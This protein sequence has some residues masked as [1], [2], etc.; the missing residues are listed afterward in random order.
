MAIR[1]AV[2]AVGH[3]AAVLLSTIATDPDRPAS[4]LQFT[5]T[6]TK[7]IIVGG[8]DVT[9]TTGVSIASG[10]TSPLYELVEDDELYGICGGTDTST[11]AVMQT[12]V[13]A[14]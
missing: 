4:A 6:G 7:S 5:N 2:V 12:G 1:T 10:A 14:A 11:A 8:S 13:A 9:A 3:T